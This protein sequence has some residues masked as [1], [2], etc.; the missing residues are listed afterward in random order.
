MNAMTPPLPRT[1]AKPAS[2]PLLVAGLLA[3]LAGAV[4]AVGYLM[5]GRLFVAFM[6]GN[7]TVLAVS[8]VEG[9]WQNAGRAAWIVLAFVGGTALGTLTGRFARPFQMP[10][11]LGLVTILLA[12][13]AAWPGADLT[14]ASILAMVLAM[15][16][17]NAA[18]DTAGG[19]PVSL[20]FVTGALVRV[21]RGIGGALAGDRTDLIW[22]AQL[23]LWG[24]LVIG[25]AFG[26]AGHLVYGRDALWA[27]AAAS[28]LLTALTAAIPRLRGTAA[29]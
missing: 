25:A 21:G 11:V 22:L 20:T 8:L 13:A 4:D 15:G 1:V 23:A 10:A 2:P 18:T 7:S 28:L 16:A 12:T 29:K 19:V 27:A 3:T 9:Q 24:G 14:T 5:L 26:T 17:I 6:S